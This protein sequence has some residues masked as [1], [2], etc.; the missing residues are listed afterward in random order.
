MIIKNEWLQRGKEIL[1]K[2]I[3]YNFI[4]ILLV[5]LI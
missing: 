2:L 3:V 1:E 4:F 5:V